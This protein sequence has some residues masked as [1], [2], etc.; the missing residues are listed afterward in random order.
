MQDFEGKTAVI[1]GG[2]SGIGLGL[3]N[4]CADL[5]M[6]VVIADIQEDALQAAVAD[7]EERQCQVHGVITNTM[8][9]DSV[10]NMLAEAQARFG[11][12]HLLFSNAGVAAARQQKALWEMSSADWDWVMG[13]NFYGVLYGIQ[14]FVP[15]MLDHGEESYIVNTAS[16]AAVMPGGGT[17]GVSKHGVLALSESLQN[18]LNMIKANIHA[19]V[20]C[21]GYVN[22]NIMDAERNRPED[23]SG[24]VA[25][26]DEAR[27]AMQ[28]FAEETLRKGM[29]TSE[30]ADI[31]FAAMENNQF[32]ILPHPAWDDMVRSRVEQI[33]ARGGVATF[34]PEYINRK[35]NAGEQV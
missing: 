13:V 24:G 14:A 29:A 23:L 28:A 27:A 7:F 6:N 12:V 21:P 3:A 26:T 35:R 25:Y 2:A 8:V 32:Y 10:R 15:H 20:L 5:R 17:Y 31:V 22:T 16:L 1:T 18:Q 4:K 34:D 33:L 11:N 9:E 30:I 19:G